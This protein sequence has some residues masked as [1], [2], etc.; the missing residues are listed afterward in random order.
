MA[1][2]HS[3]KKPQIPTFDYLRKSTK[4]EQNGKQ[5]QEKSIDQ[6]RKELDNL[7][8]PREIE[9]EG[10]TGIKVV[11]T[12]A[13]EGVSG[14]KMGSKRPGF[15]KMINAIKKY[16]EKQKVIRVDDIDRF[17]RASLDDTQEVVR[18]LKK[19][20]VRWIVTAAQGIFDLGKDANDLLANMRVA[21]AAWA[22]HDYSRKLGRRIA[23]AK[24][25][26]A[27]E[28]KRSG[29]AAP[30][31]MRSDGKGGL[32]PG[33]A[34]E[35]AV[36]RQVFDWFTNSNKSIRWI[37]A[38]LNENGTP[39]KGKRWYPSTV[40]HMLERTAY[41]GTF[42][43]GSRPNGRFYRVDEDGE[44][45]EADDGEI[46][47]KPAIQK[48]GAYEPIIDPKIFQKAQKRFEGFKTGRKPR[49]DG[50][51][52][53]RILV[54]DHCGQTMYG[55]TVNNGTVI[56]RCGTKLRQGDD[57][58]KNY[59][60]R[61]DVILPGIMEMLGEEIDA[62]VAQSLIPK[63]PKEDAAPDREKQITQLKKRIEKAEDRILDIEDKRTRQSLDAK[64]TNMRDELDQLLT[65]HEDQDADAEMADML[66]EWW[67]EFE[68]QAVSV[69]LDPKSEI[70][71]NTYPNTA[72]YIEAWGDES[73]VAKMDRRLVNE[74]LHAVGCEV[75][76]RWRTE[77]RQQRNR[78]TLER[79]RFRLGQRTDEI[80]RSVAHSRP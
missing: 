49:H 44:I 75:R 76:L 8:F 74:A 51:A 46:N 71:Q 24:R 56:Y 77:K 73:F 38:K 61:Q 11:D 35:V 58:C 42:S 45:V 30:Y 28:G 41:T 52:L 66:K 22:S 47:Q 37:A 68:K 15:Q 26:K 3:N 23:L 29:A 33:D 18:E 5:R 55:S 53:S 65:E 9:E 14:W 63:P 19:A 80:V 16:E 1:K 17:S 10:Y 62:L 67:G 2:K 78:Y 27:A 69:A 43:Y 50:Y 79:G 13:D 6:Q 31:G 40:K 20:G 12:F 4:G 59:R 70:A 64:I 21:M 57:S 36:V 54:C 60:I 7:P 32:V 48:D 39:A 25:N 34:D 72:A